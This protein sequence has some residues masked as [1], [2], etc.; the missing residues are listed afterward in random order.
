MIW[1]LLIASQ[2][3]FIELELDR[4]GLE[5]DRKAFEPFQQC[6][7]AEAGK[8]YSSGQTLNVIFNAAKDACITEGETTAADIVLNDVQRT[9]PS[10]PADRFGRFENELL[11]EL[12]DDFIPKTN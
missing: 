3:P 8:R 1:T 7:L 2:V 6:V 10:Q 5:Q 11:Y 9:V 4:I 12:A